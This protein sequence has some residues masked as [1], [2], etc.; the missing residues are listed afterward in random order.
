MLKPLIVCITTNYGKFLKRWE[1][2][3]NL[4]VSWEI[5]VQ[6][7][8]QQLE[9]YMK[10]WTGSKLGYEYTKAVYWH[11][12]YFSL[13]TEYIM[14][15][16]R[17]GESQNGIKIARRRIDSLRYADDITLMAKSKEELKCLLMWVKEKSEKA[18]LKLNI[19][20]I[21]KKH[22]GHGIP[23]LPGK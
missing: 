22:W 17:L 1:H 5:C 21:N 9:P 2:Q 3:T 10:Q 6:V 23:L 15:I 7:K 14:W 11:P 13:Y 8:K 20:K 18:D 12:A 16:A 4:P 19:I